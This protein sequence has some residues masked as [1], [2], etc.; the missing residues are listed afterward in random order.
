MNRY[1][2]ALASVAAYLFLALLVRPALLRWKTGRWGFNGLSGAV[3]SAGWC[4]GV[5]FLASM[6]AIPVALSLNVFSTPEAFAMAGLTL[7]AVGFAITLLAQSGM[8]ASW[9]IGVKETE[10]TALITTGL[11]GLVR[12]PIFTGMG[13]F[14]AGLVLLWPNVASFTSL[15]LLVLGVELQVRFVE[16]PYLRAVH[17]EAWVS[18][19][20]RVGRFI[21]GMGT[22]SGT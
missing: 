19:A 15:G 13:T 11:F 6:L 12:N 14:G 1:P 21:P 16:E 4:G 10:R 3:G 20:R 22:I 5:S 8:G 2:I 17:G 7:M 18:W 9:R